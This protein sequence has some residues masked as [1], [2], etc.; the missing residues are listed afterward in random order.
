MKNSY[1][2]IMKDNLAFVTDRKW[3]LYETPE[4]LTLAVLGEIGEL[5]EH[6][7][8][9]NEELERAALID[10]AL[11]MADIYLFYTR[12]FRMVSRDLHTDD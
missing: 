12:L 8:W 5:C 3:E 9:L 10:Y 4:R 7:A 11:E 1:G 6:A 2:D